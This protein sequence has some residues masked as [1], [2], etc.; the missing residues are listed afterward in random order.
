MIVANLPPEL[1]LFKGQTWYALVK[2]AIKR[3]LAIRSFV[4]LL[5]Y[6]DSCLGVFEHERLSIKLVQQK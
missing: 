1:F 3:I 4:K 2:V 5:I 6:H